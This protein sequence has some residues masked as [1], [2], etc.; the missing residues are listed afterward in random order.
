MIIDKK[1]HPINHLH[2]LNQA[3]QIKTCNTKIKSN[4]PARLILVLALIAVSR[5]EGSGEPM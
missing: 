5:N 3:K 2:I 1:I 4:E